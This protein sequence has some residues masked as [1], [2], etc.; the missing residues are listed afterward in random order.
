MAVCA[1]PLL[2]SIAKSSTRF[3]SAMEV[4]LFCGFP[5]AELVFVQVVDLYVRV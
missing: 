3:A 4:D 1:L 2:R 5:E